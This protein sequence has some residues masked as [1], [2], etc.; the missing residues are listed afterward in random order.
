MKKHLPINL[1]ILGLLLFQ[2]CY[3]DLDNGGIGCINAHGSKVTETRI[4]APYH[5]ITNAIGANLVIRQH[6]DQEVEITAQES[7]LN[8]ITTQVID[9]ELIIDSRRC[10]KNAEIDIYIKAPELRAIYNIG[11]GDIYGEQVWHSDDLT[12]KITGSGTI[13]A[14][15]EADQV[16]SEIT[17]SGNMKLFGNVSQSAIKISGSGNISAFNLNSNLQDITISGSGNCEVTAKDMLEVSITG[18]GNVYYQGN[19][20]VSADVSGSGGVFK[21]N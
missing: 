20:T 5:S 15:F 4:P 8:D 19:P 16:Y 21:A 1:A 6:P 10:F 9:G 7:I 14:E 2:G 17:G 12:L 13:N 3:I 18:S 11:S